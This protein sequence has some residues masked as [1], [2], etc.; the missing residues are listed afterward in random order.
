MRSRSWR[1]R[2]LVAVLPVVVS[3][4]SLAPAS[5]A[6]RASSGWLRPVDGELVRPF[7]EP[8]SVYGPGHRGADLAAAPGTPVRVANDGEVTFAGPVAGTLHVTVLH[9]GGLRTTYSFLES[10]TVR[11]GAVLERGDVVGTAGGTNDDHDASVLHLGLRLGERYL[12]PML[13]FGPLDLAKVVRLAPFEAPSEEVWTVADERRALVVA[14]QLPT[15]GVA[16]APAADEGSCGDGIPVVGG[17]VSS[18]CDLAGWIGDRAGQALDAGLAT[19]RAF[20]GIADDVLSELRSRLTDTL[21]ELR[22]LPAALAGALART[23][24]GMLALDLV[25]IG[26]RFY[27]TVTAECSDDAPDADGT[28]GSRHRVMVVAGVNSSGPAG[29]RGPT[30]DLDVRA[31]GYLPDE[32]EVRWYS[33]AADGGSYRGPDTLGPL[34]RAAQ[35]LGDQLRAMQREEP[36]REVDLIA[37]SQGGVVVATFLARH[38]KAHDRT[39]P[40]LGNVVTVAS[41]LAGAPLAT[42]G[43]V[44]R[45]V[46]GGEAALDGVGAVVPSIPPPNASSVRELSERSALIRE[47]Q[48]RGVPEHFDVTS[49]GASEDLVVPAESITLDGARETVVAVNSLSQHGDVLRDEDGLR[50]MRAALE[51]RA[52]PC[53]GLD[54]ALRSAVAPV[55]ISRLERGFVS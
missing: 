16:P 33:Y 8:A 5:A 38:Y 30:V 10:V 15:P 24:F 26:R 45:A 44:I 50:A 35:R 14:L 49:I 3:V 51:G 4:V 20:T 25:E 22:R 53:V 13:L 36:G 29:D 40:P 9:A 55:V 47:I 48:R 52:P 6:E 41:P 37:H 34:D 27:D 18:A 46:P 54:T 17:I 31:L 2:A 23:P 28:G 42:T 32:D 43:E 12:D 7:E 1:R 39:L 21:D 11:R 19:V